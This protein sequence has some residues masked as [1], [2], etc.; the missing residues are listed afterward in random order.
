M[1]QRHQG[2]APRTRAFPNFDDIGQRRPA[3]LY[4][5]KRSRLRRRGKPSLKSFWYILASFLLAAKLPAQITIAPS[6]V[7]QPS[8][9]NLVT[10]TAN[11]GSRIFPN[12]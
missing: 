8:S 7:I 6:L 12:A 3:E 5:A 4:C 11:I 10:V 1:R 9:T 2:G